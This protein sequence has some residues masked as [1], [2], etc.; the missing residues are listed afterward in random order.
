MGVG[1][2]IR[3]AAIAA[4]TLAI[5]PPSIADKVAHVRRAPQARRHHCHWPG[6]QKQVPPAKWGC[7]RHWFMLP[8][9]LRQAIWQAYRPGQEID[10]R[11]SPDYVD[12]A[13]RV[14]AWIAQHHP[15]APETARLL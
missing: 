4:A 13:K 12:V 11:P 15:P 10:Q 2:T 9:D 3:L 7:P 14:Q 5:A 8:A 1:R 6:C